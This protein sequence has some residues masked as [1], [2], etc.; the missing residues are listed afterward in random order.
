MITFRLQVQNAN[1]VSLAFGS[2]ASAVN[3]WQ[4]FI[5]PGIRRD[6]IRPWLRKQFA[7]EG[8]QGAHGRWQALSPGYAARKAKL[9]PGKKILEA[10]GALK[11]DLLSEMNEGETSPRMMLYGTK[12]PYGIYHQTG[13]KRGGK[14]RMV[15][16]RIF[17]PEMSDQPGTFKGLIKMSVARSVSG[18]ARQLG[19]FLGATDPTMAAVIGRRAMMS[20]GSDTSFPVS[21]GL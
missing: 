4:Q 6:A 16:R 5:W 21:E 19:F 17:D 1:K 11:D 15:A 9:Y 12:I 3:D 2:L 10:T 14:Q 8:A 18:Y 7:L 13:T 20:R